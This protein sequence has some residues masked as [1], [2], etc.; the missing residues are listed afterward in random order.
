MIVARFLVALAASRESE[1]GESEAEQRELDR[2]LEEG[3]PEQANE[4]V[5]AICA[6]FAIE[7]ARTA[8]NAPFG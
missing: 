3:D 8:T 1:S 7:L 4:L 5:A 6:R 2:R